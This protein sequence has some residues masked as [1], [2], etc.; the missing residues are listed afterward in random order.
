MA[1]RSATQQAELETNQTIADNASQSQDFTPQ[2]S[3]LEMEAEIGAR[4]NIQQEVDK[5]VEKQKPAGIDP[6]LLAAMNARGSK[7]N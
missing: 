7:K 6:I 3:D 1:Q 4:A 2:K 5:F